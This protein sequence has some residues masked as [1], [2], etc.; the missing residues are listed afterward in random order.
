[1]ASAIPSSGLQSPGVGDDFSPGELIL[2]KLFAQFVARSDAKLK[3]IAAQRQVYMN[4]ANGTIMLTY[5][6]ANVCRLLTLQS[7]PLAKSLQRGE[8]PQFDQLLS[9]LKEVAR[10]CLRS[11]LKTI[12]DWR[13][14]QMKLV[15]SVTTWGV[16]VTG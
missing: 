10:F 3:H 6:Q 5:I 4:A 14:L 8:D 11:L 16:P 9:S 15:H 2:K 13:R 7:Y 1:M 12:F